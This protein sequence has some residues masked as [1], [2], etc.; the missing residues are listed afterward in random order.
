ML[1]LNSSVV[2]GRIYLYIY[3]LIFSNLRRS[4]SLLDS[5]LFHLIER[6]GKDGAKYETQ[7]LQFILVILY[8]G[9]E[10]LIKLV[11]EDIRKTMKNTSSF[12]SNRKTFFIGIVNHMINSPIFE[13]LFEKYQNIEALI[14]L[15]NLFDVH[16]ENT[17]FLQIKS[18]YMQVIEKILS[19]SVLSE[20]L[21]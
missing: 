17:A 20:K 6:Q 4:I 5:K 12:D 13:E 16:C 3:F 1:D 2:R 7:C 15:L 14:S 8:E 10:T 18:Q 9:F 21:Q 11:E 19:N